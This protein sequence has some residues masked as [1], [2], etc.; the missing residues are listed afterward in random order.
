MFNER[1]QDELNFSVE[2]KDGEA[3]QVVGEKENR[4]ASPTPQSEIIKFTQTGNFLGLGTESDDLS[5]YMR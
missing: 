4:V 2:F 5:E 1:L 3:V